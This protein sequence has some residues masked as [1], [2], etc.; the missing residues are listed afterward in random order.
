[1]EYVEQR[2]GGYYVA[3]T[4]VSLDSVVY[5]YRRGESSEEIADK[6]QAL[7][8]HQINGAVAF[9]IANREIVDDYLVQ[10]N[11]EFER[12]RQ[13]SRKKNPE[14]YAKLTAAKQE[15]LARRS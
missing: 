10:Q 13:E 11:L 7:N 14:L 15:L 5:A 4:R 6:F 12:M 2:N 9:Y 8:L 1:M 3:G